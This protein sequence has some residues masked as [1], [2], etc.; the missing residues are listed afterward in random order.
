M[1]ITDHPFITALENDPVQ[2]EKLIRLYA[3]ASGSAEAFQL[4]DAVG[5]TIRFR[6]RKG[7]ARVE[8]IAPAN[9]DPGQ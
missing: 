9:R 8:A 1:P 5:K 7:R 2:R 6:L 3:A 4:T